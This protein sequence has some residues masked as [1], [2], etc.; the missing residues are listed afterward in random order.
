MTFVVAEPCVDVLDRSCVDV[1]PVD[2]IYE[3]GRMV[4]IQ[5]EE[6]IDCGTCLQVFPMD[7]IFHEDDL[8]EEWSPFTQYNAEFFAT[9]GSPGRRKI[10][11]RG[12]CL[13]RHR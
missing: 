5:P 13:S 10:F 9:V 7:A 1:C 4:F 11:R 2:C 3:G 12:A 6:Y 8:P